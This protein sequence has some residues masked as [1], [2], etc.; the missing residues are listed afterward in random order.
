MSPGASASPFDQRVPQAIARV[1]VARGVDS[2]EK[3]RL[4]LE[5]PHRLPH[6]PQRLPGMDSALQRLYHAVERQEKVGIFGDFDVDGVT[7][8]AIIA[9]GLSALGVPVQPYLP[10]R[11]DE[12]HGLS[13]EAVSHLTQ[14]GVTLI[15]TV[16]CGMSSVS[17]VAR[18]R[19]VHCDVIITDHHAPPDTVPQAT[20]T[21]NPQMPGNTYPFI[22][23][24][25]AGLAFK[26]MQGIYEYYGQPWP[27]S[28][29]ELAA[30]GTIAD[31]VPLLDENRFLVQ[32]GLKELARTQRPGLRALYR[33]ASIQ[34]RSLTSET[35]SYQLAP[36]LNAPGR[37]GH[38][39]TSYRLLT[40]DS[41]AEAESLADEIEAMNQERRSL[42]EEAVAIGMA[43]IEE[44]G[45]LPPLLMV[46][47]PSITPGV[48]GLVAGRL[49]ET[50]HRPSV[51]MA[52]VDAERVTASARSVPE[53]NLIECFAACE[54]LFVKYGGHSQAAG[55]TILRQKIPELRNRLSAMLPGSFV[56]QQAHPVIKVDA[57]VDLRELTPDVLRWIED[58]EPFGKGN[59]QPVFLT[60]G[61]RVTGVQYIGRQGQHV[62]FRA[63]Q[64]K[65][66]WTVLAF[67]QA[68][69]WSYTATDIDLVYTV[70]ADFWNG[71]RR[72]N[73]RALDFRPS[74]P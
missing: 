34:T 35:I 38:S 1:L 43:Q 5:P 14:G 31:L 55:F 10:H 29:L 37:M 61:L 20:A 28:L 62:K 9:E 33:R 40:S 74:S 27:R 52:Y 69:K 46:E 13:D 71:E 41:P 49:A 64:G 19:Q 53:F 36:R 17:E 58:L 11:L 66:E 54:D 15:I 44:Y 51:A 59:T 70:M 16:D 42:T 56:V 72:L 6:D 65:S 63:R 50:F 32:E 30:L 39:M 23:L 12:G 68:N 22:D 18:A 4:F 24:C 67:N 26:L 60:R 45:T 3:L 7:G 25:G 21:I 2:P 8:T 73:L 47:D 48:A 57:E